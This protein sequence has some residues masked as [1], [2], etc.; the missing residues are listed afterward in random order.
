M[1]VTGFRVFVVF[2]PFLQTAVSGADLQRSQIVQSLL[3]LCNEVCF[4]TV[5]ATVQDL[6]R[7]QTVHE[8]IVDDHQIH[9]RRVS[10]LAACTVSAD[11][12]ILRRV[13]G[14]SDQFARDRGTFRSRDK[15]IQNEERGFFHNGPGAVTQKFLVL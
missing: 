8:Q 12:S 14:I 15:E 3:D 6:C 5:F 4:K 1:T 11:E 9:S 10:E 2:D 7:V 13:A